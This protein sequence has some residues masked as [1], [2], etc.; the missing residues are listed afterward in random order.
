MTQEEK[1]EIINAVLSAILTNSKT[2]EQLTPTE[3]LSDDDAIEVSGGRRISYAAFL[4]AVQ[5]GVQ[6][7]LDGYLTGEAAVAWFAALEN[8]PANYVDAPNNPVQL[9]WRQSPIVLLDSMGEDLDC[10]DDFTAQVGDKW[11]D[12]TNSTTKNYIFLKT[13]TGQDGWPIGSGNANDVLY[14]NKRTG[15]MYLWDGTDMVEL[16]GATGGGSN[17]YIDKSGPNYV[18]I[19]IDDNTPVI[20][21]S[22]SSIVMSGDNKTATFTVSGHNLTAPIKINGGNAYFSKSPSSISPV[23][24]IVEATTVTVTFGGSTDDTD[25]LIVSSVGA[26]AQTIHVAY[27]A[28]AGPNF[29]VSPAT[30]SFKAATN[31]TQTKQVAVQGSLLTDDVEVTAGGAFQVSLQSGSGFANS[32]TIPKASAL[33]GITV[34]VRYTAGSSATTG[35]LTLT[36]DGAADKTVDLTGAVSTLTVSPSSLSL[37]TTANTPTTGE[38]TI[39]GSNLTNGVT[40]A[41]TD[42]NSVFSL[43]KN[44]LTKAEAEGGETITVTYS[45]T[46]AGTHNASIAINWDGTTQT[47][48]ISGTAA[49]GLPAGYT[50]IPYIQGH[51]K[52]LMTAASFTSQW[53]LD[54]VCDSTPSTTQILACSNSA[55]GHYAGALTNGKFGV[56]AGA[57]QYVSAGVTTRTTVVITFSANG[58][59]LTAGGETVTRTGDAHPGYVLILGSNDNPKYLFEGKCYGIRCLNED[60]GT[61]ILCKNSNNQQG[62]YNTKQ[63]VFFNLDA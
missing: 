55:G 63:G 37:S 60:L 61:F 17:V 56:G 58:I 1:Q 27:T 7:M 3:S 46:A 45:P 21:V 30:L 47:V 29:V 6:L 16:V 32:V 14:V 25:D 51:A 34:Y 41:L 15:R 38:F 12:P 42:T 44:S 48:S 49:Q 35:T 52:A 9:H 53:E 26:T 19:I 57:G 22:T 18:D 5:E 40:L 31:Q 36:S 24:G 39:Q 43:S 10:D 4:S 8:N 23:G 33:A 62:V 50:E 11:W 54:V 13:S 2:I 20:E 28:V 59:S